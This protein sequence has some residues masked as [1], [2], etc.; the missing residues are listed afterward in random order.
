MNFRELSLSP[1]TLDAIAAMGY[2]TPSPIQEMAIPILLQ[3]R[4]LIGQARTGTG[5]TAAFGIPL[6]ERHR[7][8]RNGGVV[9][10]VLVPTRELCL[11]VADEVT[12]IAKGSPLR[13]LTIY[14]GV[15]FGNQK[16]DLARGGTMVLVA[17]PGRLI[18][19]MQQGTVRLDKVQSLVLDEADRMLDMGFLPDVDRILRTIPKARQ[20][21]LFSATVPDPIRRLSERFLSKPEVV[22]V[23]PGPDAT[24]NAEQFHLRVEKALKTRSLVA[25]LAKE[26]PARTVVFTRTKHLAKRLARSLEGAG[27]KAVA[28]QGN[29][30]QNARERAMNSFRAGHVEILVATD[31]ASRGIDVPEITHVVNYDMPDEPEAYVHRIGRTGRMGR[32]GRAFIFVQSDE[33]RDMKGLQQRSPTPIL[34]YELGELPPEPTPSR[35]PAGDA[36]PSGGQGHGGR[37]NPRSRGPRQWHQPR[38]HGAPSSGGHGG[39]RQESRPRSQAWR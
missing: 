27:H 28:L 17:T 18:D 12:E 29:M 8:T 32:R 6:V 14:G 34:P 2:E 35:A 21:S 24:P 22:K 4:D 31:I 13:I 16:S 3:G 37:G 23:E 20:T 30:S 5:K 7:N 1:G 10:L 9:A 11:Q 26:K 25:L 36:R 39:A 15:G 33:V 38:G 19:H